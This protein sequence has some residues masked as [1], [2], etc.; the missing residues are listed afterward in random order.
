M[1]KLSLLFTLSLVCFIS[2]AQV[3]RYWKLENYTNPNEIETITESELSED[4]EKIGTIFAKA[5]GV[6]I[7]SAINSVNNR[8]LRKLKTETSMRGG[9]HILF[10]HE[11]QE[12]NIFSKT[13]AYSAIIYRSPKL[14]IEDLK[15]VLNA[16]NF[17]F[18]LE[19]KYNRNKFSH[20]DNPINRPLKKLEWNEPY[21]KNGKIIIEIT[22]NIGS[23][24]R[25]IKYEVIAFSETQ[26]LLFIEDIPSIEMRL[27]S[28]ERT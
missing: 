26:I 9:S 5:K 27:I 23:S 13:T 12:N 21:L 24:N 16:N 25:L 18:K 22:E 1:E 8:A 6:T 20:L 17:S 3:D 11:T 4:F 19:R 7:I 14:N 15:N 2:M 10:L 28:L